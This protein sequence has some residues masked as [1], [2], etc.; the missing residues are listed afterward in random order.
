MEEGGKLL[1]HIQSNGWLTG[2]VY[3]NV[4]AL[5]SA[6]EGALALTRGVDHT[7]SSEDTLVMEVSTGHMCLFPSSLYHG[8]VPFKGEEER[9]VLAFDMIPSLH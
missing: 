4:P 2:S 3:I 8:T 6:S 7:F 9:I 1:P 5:K